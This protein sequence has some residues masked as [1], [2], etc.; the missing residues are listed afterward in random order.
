[1][2]QDQAHIHNQIPLLDDVCE[3]PGKIQVTQKMC[4]RTNKHGYEMSLVANCFYDFSKE[5]K[6]LD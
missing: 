3:S 5:K 4:I 2:R 6:N 1:M